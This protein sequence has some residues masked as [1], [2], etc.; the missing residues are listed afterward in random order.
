MSYFLILAKAFDSV[1]HERLL[2]KLYSLGIDSKLLNWLRHFLPCRKQRVVVRGTFSNWAPVISGTPQGTILGPILFLSYIND[3]VDSVS[4]KIQLFADDTKIYR[5]L[6]N[7]SLD[8]QYLQTDLNNLGKWAK[9]W[10][11]RFNEGKCEA[12]RITHSRDK[13]N[14]KYKL[15]MVLKDVKSFKDLTWSEHISTIVNKANQVLGLIRQTVG[16]A[17]TTTFSLLY[18]TL[19]RPLLEYAA[20][21]WNPYLVKDIHAIESVQRR[22][23]RLALRQKRGDMSY[24][25]RCNMLHCPV[26]GHISLLSNVLRSYLAY[27]T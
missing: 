5:E 22:A 18:K 10:Q 7:P 24:E 25:E 6:C 14:T 11:L 1:P 17:Y 3:I 26:V 27:R 19:V 15:G 21:I 16:T 4:S 23:S 9:K 20:P 8:E 12:M 2:I 13:S